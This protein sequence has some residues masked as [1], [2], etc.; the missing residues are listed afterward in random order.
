VDYSISMILI[1]LF[2]FL[3]A[4][5]ISKPLFKLIKLPYP[6]LL[7]LIGFLLHSTQDLLAL[8][9]KFL[10]IKEVAHDVI[11]WVLL[12]TLVFETAYNL[13]INKL[14]ANRLA[15]FMLALPGVLIS[16]LVVAIIISFFTYLN[17]HLALLLG[18]ILSATDPSAVITAFRQLGAPKDLIM[19]IEGESLF[20]DATAIT[21]TKILVVSFAVAEGFWSILWSSSALFLLTLGGGIF[22]GW[23]VV[24][25]AYVS[26]VK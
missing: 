10:T 17:W 3:S 24:C 22:C 4:T 20:N 14:T 12:P 11:L 21:L 19:L 13:D 1:I 18:A 8:P 15:I 16:T 2:V 9:L 25:P 26:A 5:V 7:I 23:L 6:I